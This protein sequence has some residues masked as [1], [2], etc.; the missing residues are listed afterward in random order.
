MSDPALA[1]LVFGCFALL[2]V[3]R[4]PVAF[5]LGLSAFVFFFASGLPALSVVQ[6]IATQIA[7]PTLLAIPFFILCGEIMSTG[8]MARRLVD[9][10]NALIGFVRGG[11]AMVNVMA[12]L[13]F[14]GMSGSSV[15][16]TASIGPV[17]IPTMA[18][19][20][21][22]RDFSVAVT[23]ASSTQ[24]IILPPSHN[25][26]LYSLAAGGTV[27]I[28]ALFLAGYVPGI[29]VG[30]S[31][32]IL[33]AWVAKRRGY[34]KGKSFSL[35][36]ALRAA[37][38][39]LPALLTPF[40]ILVPLT[41]GWAPAHQSAVIAVVW[42]VMVSSFVYRSLDLRAY[43]GILRRAVRTSGMVMILIGAAAAFGEALTYLHVPRLLAEWLSALPASR[44]ALLLILNVLVLALGAIMDM[45]ALI[46]ILTPI[47]LPV[48]E[49]LGLDPIQF[50]I[51]L[52]LNLG[53]GLC[54]PPVGSTLF[55]GCAIGKTSIESTSRAL[56]PFYLVMIVVLLLVTFIPELSLWLPDWIARST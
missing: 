51:I 52:L 4:V 8:G 5:S 6:K 11:L 36:H 17:L 3:L 43:G 35:R 14:G 54:T 25:A 49:G 56:V 53:I 31:L 23:V 30:L 20:G 2:L 39:A 13:F 41:L 22:D 47:L 29:L 16:D 48:A 21:Y 50:G 28:Q 32:M 24:G 42:S 15:A 7:E 45:A 55:V 37:A 33:S 34:P 38:S 40:I 26:I 18:E 10:A 1:L 19:R 9:L 12:S 44:V 27:S 46:V